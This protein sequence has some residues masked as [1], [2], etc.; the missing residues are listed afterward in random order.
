MLRRLHHLLHFSLRA[1][2]LVLH[3]LGRAQKGGCLKI[4]SFPE[5]LHPATQWHKLP[6]F[7]APKA[8]YPKERE[9]EGGWR[10]RL[11]FTSLRSGRRVMSCGSLHVY[12]LRS[13][14]FGLHLG[15]RSSDSPESNTHLGWTNYWQDKLQVRFVPPIPPKSDEKLANAHPEMEPQNLE[16]PQAEF[17]AFC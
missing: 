1:R 17:R 7:G 8:Q 14:C 6:W 15:F 4:H 11:V 10:R 16:K 3:V 13:M 9:R 2:D 5:S 12:G